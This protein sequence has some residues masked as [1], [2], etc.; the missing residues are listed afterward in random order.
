MAFTEVSRGRWMLGRSS[1][2]QAVPLPLI[3]DR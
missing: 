1:G 2:Y 3:E